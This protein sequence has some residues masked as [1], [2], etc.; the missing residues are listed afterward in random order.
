VHLLIGYVSVNI[1]Q[2]T[3]VE[4]LKGGCCCRSVAN[5]TWY[6]RCPKWCKE[7]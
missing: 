5:W 4:H 7:L 2:R 6:W 1:P 3:D